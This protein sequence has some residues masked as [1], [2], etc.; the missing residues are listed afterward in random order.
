MSAQKQIDL[1]TSEVRAQQ[2][3]QEQT[4]SECARVRTSTQR[5]VNDTAD[6]CRNNERQTAECLETKKEVVFQEARNAEISKK[7]RDA[8][9]R[10]KEREIALLTARRE[11]E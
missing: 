3:V 4:D 6:L 10:L 9:L 11:L 8:E 5:V 7:V 1:K 2:V